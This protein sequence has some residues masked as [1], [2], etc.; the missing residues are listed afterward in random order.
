MHYLQ[1]FDPS[2]QNFTASNFFALHQSQANNNMQN[3]AS[4]FAQNPNGYGQQNTPRM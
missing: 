2:L 4:E 1:M 3:I